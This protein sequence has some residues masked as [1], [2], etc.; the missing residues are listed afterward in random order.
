MAGKITLTEVNSSDTSLEVL[1][2]INS[3]L[4]AQAAAEKRAAEQSKDTGL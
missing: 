2:K 1:A 4:D 3:L